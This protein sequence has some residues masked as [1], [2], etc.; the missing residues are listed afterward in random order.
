MSLQLPP[1]WVSAV[2]AVA[3]CW[4]IQIE[5]YMA[6]VCVLSTLCINL[7]MLPVELVPARPTA[8]RLF[9]RCSPPDCCSICTSMS[10]GHNV[11][12][13]AVQFQLGNLLCTSTVSA[14]SAWSHALAMHSQLVRTEQHQH[15]STLCPCGL[16]SLTLCALRRQ[17]TPGSQTSDPGGATAGSAAMTWFGGPTMDNGPHIVRPSLILVVAQVELGWCCLCQHAVMSRPPQSTAVL[18]GQVADGREQRA[19]PHCVSAVP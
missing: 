6:A 10:T 7:C 18:H 8:L 9:T 2:A 14:V 15:R 19:K 16:V 11:R 17:G 12:S 13:S 1:L 5:A 4:P 3:T